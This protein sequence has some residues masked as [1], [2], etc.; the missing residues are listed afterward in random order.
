MEYP[1]QLHHITGEP[2]PYSHALGRWTYKPG[3]EITAATMPNGHVMLTLSTVAHN[4]R[5][6]DHQTRP[7]T[8]TRPI[9]AD[10]TDEQVRDELVALT[11]WWAE[12]ECHEFMRWDGVIIREP[13]DIHGN[14]I[15]Q[16]DRVY[17]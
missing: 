10:L 5:R 17:P 7:F 6:G 14:A 3:V 12:H 13:H 16:F 9:R 1:P 2:S 15:G 11:R 4:S 8:V